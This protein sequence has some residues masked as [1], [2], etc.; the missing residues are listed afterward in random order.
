[1]VP[2]LKVEKLKTMSKAKIIKR[3][4]AC[5]YYIQQLTPKTVCVYGNNS[6]VTGSLNKCYRDI[7]QTL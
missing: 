3:L 7:F 6:T 5:G 4:T 2:A 1:M